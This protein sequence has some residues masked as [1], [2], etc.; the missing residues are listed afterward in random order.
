MPEL[1]IPEDSRS[2]APAYSVAQFAAEIKQ[3]FPDYAS[4]PDDHLVQE[5]VAK[6]PEYASWV[7]ID[8]RT[9]IAMRKTNPPATAH[10]D[11]NAGM[12]DI[13]ASDVLGAGAKGLAHLA[14]VPT[15]MAEVPQAV[16]DSILNLLTFGAH[17]VIKTGTQMAGDTLAPAAAY[18]SGQ[19][20]TAEQNAGAIPIIGRPALETARP[21][22]AVS[23]GNAPTRA[24]NLGAIESGTSLAGMAAMAHPA[25]AGAM[26]R[27]LPKAGAAIE[28]AGTKTYA[29]ALAPEGSPNRPLA[30]SL[31]SQL[32]NDGKVMANPKKQL[33]TAFGGNQGAEAVPVEKFRKV[34]AQPNQ[35]AE[36]QKKYP[37]ATITEDGQGNFVVNKPGERSLNQQGADTLADGITPEA[38]NWWK[39]IIVKGGAGAIGG[40]LGF[41]AGGPPGAAVGVGVAEAPFVMKEIVQSPLWRTTSGVVKTSLG[42]AMQAQDFATVTN[43]AAKVLGG[44]NLEDSYGHDQALFALMKSIPPG[45]DL[46][47]T[48]QD[49]EAIY[50]SA[51]GTHVQVP[52]NVQKR[53]HDAIAGRK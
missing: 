48:L 34:D 44:V 9:A 37:A 17:G 15:S 6:H 47:Q 41:M 33:G 53:T 28:E 1:S 25:V 21:A 19:A 2:S 29:N 18:A 4:W 51:D 43:V 10:G 24:E 32:A 14:G 12:N 49:H 22:I 8:P 3:K 35:L 13:G 31:G 20:P 46:H 16:K 36:L 40:K 5:V 42:K 11:P 52:F 39:S 45:A 50:V 30:E 23:H 38:T 26:E 7:S 27:V